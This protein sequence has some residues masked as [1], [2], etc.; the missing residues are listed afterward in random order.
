VHDANEARVALYRTKSAIKGHPTASAAAAPTAEL[1][2]LT[3]SIQTMNLSNT[4]TGLTRLLYSREE[5]EAIYSLVSGGAG[6][7]ATD[8]K[9]RRT[10]AMSDALSQYRI[11]HFA[12]HGL[13]NSGRPELFGLVFLLVDET[14]KPQ[15]GFRLF[16]VIVN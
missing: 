12:T 14:T 15:D 3:R 11:V 4:R 6:L 13:L 10:T 7:K 9:A 2:A 5:A 8:F 1:P 16:H